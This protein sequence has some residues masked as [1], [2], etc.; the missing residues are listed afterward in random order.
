MVTSND[1][2][3]INRYRYDIYDDI[4]TWII[5]DRVQFDNATVYR[6][7]TITAT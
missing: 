2:N 5:G 7:L 4:I 1:T 6:H 3:I